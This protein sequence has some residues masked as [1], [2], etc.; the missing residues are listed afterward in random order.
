MTMMMSTDGAVRQ[1]IHT[2]SPADNVGTTD[3]IM[4]AAAAVAATVSKG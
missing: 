1:S 3:V 4:C 2:T